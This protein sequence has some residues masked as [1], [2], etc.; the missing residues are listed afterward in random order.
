MPKAWFIYSGSFTS[1][2]FLQALSGLVLAK[3]LVDHG[4]REASSST[5]KNASRLLSASSQ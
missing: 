2:T 5:F 4:L 3:F 1:T